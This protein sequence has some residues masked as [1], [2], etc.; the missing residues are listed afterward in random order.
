[1]ITCNFHGRLGN[2]LFQIATV[3]SLSKQIGVDF[4]LPE[5]THAGHRGDI[6]VDLSMFGYDFNRG[7]YECETEYNEKEFEYVKINPKD[8][9]RLGG[10]F[11]SWKYFEDIKEDLLNKYFIPS[12]NVLKSL[13]RYDISKNSLGISVRRGDYLMLQHNH[14]VLDT[15]YYQEILNTYFQNNIDQIFVF[16]DDLDWCKLVFG[17]DVHYVQ[18]TTG[19]QL[20]LMSKMKHL[21]LSN[22]T[23]AWWG[24]YLNQQN[25]IIIAPDPWF[26]SDNSDIN[27]NDLYCDN[28]IR[29]NH[30]IEI[31]PYTITENMYN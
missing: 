4:I 3:I 17:T 27:I 30:K 8:K 9:L 28:W 5:L 19:T 10:F 14:C 1:M 31:H 18:D 26:G 23:F 2:N 16:S 29:F 13:K 12:Q 6:P 7:S 25:G 20:F 21:I 22:S 15:T 24:A 11:Q